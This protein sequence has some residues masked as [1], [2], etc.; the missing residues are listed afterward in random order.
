MMLGHTPGFQRQDVRGRAISAIGLPAVL[1]MLL[2]QGLHHAVPLGLGEDRGRRDRHAAPVAFDH[3]GARAGHRP[4]QP[5][6]VHQMFEA[7]NF[8]V[9]SFVPRLFDYHPLSIPAPYN[10]SNIDSDEVLF[11]AEGDFMSRKGIERG[12]F[13]LH[14]GG[15]PHGPHPG[16]VEKS[17]GAKWTDELAVMCDTFRPMYPTKAAL[18]MD[19]HAY[20]ASW[21]DAPA[22]DAPANGHCNGHANVSASA[23]APAAGARLDP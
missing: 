23:G 2:R 7:H 5:P 9:C 21:I 18:G 12:S 13:T 10:H 6:P 16:T 20:P 8:V 17:L 3:G 15:I 1:R 14:P 22:P 19:D 11:Y 4:R